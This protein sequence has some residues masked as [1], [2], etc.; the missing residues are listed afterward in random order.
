MSEI[1]I[2]PTEAFSLSSEERMSFAGHPQPCKVSGPPGLVRLVQNGR[3]PDGEFWF[4]EAVFSQLRQKAKLDLGSQADLDLQSFPMRERVGLYMKLCL[5]NDLAICKN[6][7]ENFD[8]YVILPL[9][10]MDAIVAWVGKIRSQPV[11][12]KGNPADFTKAEYA[13]RIRIHDQAEIGG[14]RLLATEK[15]YVI[16][17]DFATNRSYRNRISAP[18][19]L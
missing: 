4:S 5:R 19:P 14:V 13:E 9:R 16:H 18:F 8:S 7:T 2:K 1:V 11:Y 17:F 6:W 12:D 3:R 10:P 15:Q